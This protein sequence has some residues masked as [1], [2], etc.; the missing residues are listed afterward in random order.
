MINRKLQFVLLA[1]CAGMPLVASATWLGQGEVGAALS[2]NSTGAYSTTFAGKVN[3][4]K[5][6]GQWKYA[7]G[8][9][10]VYTS[11]KAEAKVDDPNPVEKTT[12][13]RW[14][15]HHQ[16]DYKFSS[17]A[18]VFGSLRY[19][20]DK[21][22]SYRNQSVLAS[23]LGYQWLDTTETKLVTDLGVGYKRFKPQDSVSSDGEAV[24]TGLLDLKQNLSSNLTLLNKFSFES[25][26]SNTLFQDDLAVQTKMTD[27]FALSVGYQLRYNTKPLTSTVTGR[28]FAHSDRLMTVNLVYDFK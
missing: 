22:G 23:G 10:T 15:V 26:S 25:G 13:N 4:A 5:E 27:A 12:D 28:Q 21:V 24:L 19:E 9:S 6:A 7:F 18:F 2:N 8:A 1:A 11:A 20:N 3:A 16:T 17:Q 14:E